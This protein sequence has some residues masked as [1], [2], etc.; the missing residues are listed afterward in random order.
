MTTSVIG[1]IWNALTVTFSQ[2]I[3]QKSCRDIVS[4]IFLAK[5]CFRFGKI[6]FSNF[7]KSTQGGT[8]MSLPKSHV[9]SYLKKSDRWV[10]KF[11]ELKNL[12]GRPIHKK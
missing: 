3:T 9:K 2:Q 7:S 11:D 6:T 10:P 4:D 12:S 5:I 8:L 1:Y